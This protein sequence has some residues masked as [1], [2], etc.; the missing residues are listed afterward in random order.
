MWRVSA[1][2]KMKVRFMFHLFRHRIFR[3]VA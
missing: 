2:M 1:E 3:E